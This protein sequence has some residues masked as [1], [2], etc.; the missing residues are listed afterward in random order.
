MLEEDAQR[1]RLAV[2]R[3][4]EG[5][6]QALEAR[7]VHY[8]PALD[9]RR[10]DARVPVARREVERR[11]ARGGPD[12]CWIE[13]N[14]APGADLLSEFCQILTRYSQ[15]FASKIAFFSIFQN[16]QDFAKFCKNFATFRKILHHFAKIFEFSEIFQTFLKNFSKILQNSEKFCSILQI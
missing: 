16:L 5:R 15:T 6:R 8:S 14:Y 7:L 2:Q 11:Q 13:L 1:V 4:R 12:L 3:R 10:D 9:E